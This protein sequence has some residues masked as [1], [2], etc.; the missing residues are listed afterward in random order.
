MLLCVPLS[1]RLTHLYVLIPVF[2]SKPA[3]HPVAAQK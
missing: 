3:A 2:A 1:E